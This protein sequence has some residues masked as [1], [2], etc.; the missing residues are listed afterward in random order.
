MAEYSGFFDGDTLYG[1]DEFNRYFDNIY[2]SG[3]SVDD[4]NNMTLSC[5]ASNDNIIISEGFAII[6][7]FYL[8]SDSEKILNIGRNANYNRIDRVV[9]RLNLSTKKV[10]LEHKQGVA[11]SSPVAPNLQRDNLIYE[12]SLCQIEVPKNGSINVI[13]ERFRNELCGAIR[14]KNLSELE[15]MIQSSQKIWDSWVNEEKENWNNLIDEKNDSWNK[16][17]SNQQ[18]TG[19]RQ[20]YIQEQ[21]PGNSVVGSIWIKLV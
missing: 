15:T 7:G 8:Y 1:Q 4:N 18:G 12:L 5:I 11:G 14:P 6:K 17:F 3:V 13:D 21:N 10:T 9:I 2:C 16:W 20:I 19:W